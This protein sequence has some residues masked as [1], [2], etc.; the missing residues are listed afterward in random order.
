MNMP[1]PACQFRC[2]HG[3]L[4]DGVL[5]VGIGPD[6]TLDDFQ[7]FGSCLDVHSSWTVGARY[8]LKWTEFRVSSLEEGYLVGVGPCCNSI[9]RKPSGLGPGVGALGTP[10]ASG[11]P[12]GLTV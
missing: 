6:Q 7:Q 3:F 5:G 4:L 1:N 10:L 8:E 2:G 11:E 9:F 12:R